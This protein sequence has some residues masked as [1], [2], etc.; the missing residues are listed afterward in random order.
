MIESIY[1]VSLNRLS[2]RRKKM[3]DTLTPFQNDFDIYFYDAIDWKETTMEEINNQGF[4][5]YDSWKIINS[6]NRW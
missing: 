2:E 5:I 6:S 3:I 1:C 4:Y